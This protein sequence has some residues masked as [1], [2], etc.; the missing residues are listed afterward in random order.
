MAVKRKRK[1]NY[2][3]IFYVVMAFLIILL[4]IYGV[5]CILKSSDTEE[6]YREA[7]ENS[8]ETDGATHPDSDPSQ[9]YAQGWKILF[10]GD[11][12]FAGCIGRSDLPGGDYDLLMQSIMTRLITLDGR[13]DVLPGHGKGSTIADEGM[14]NPFLQPFNEPDFDF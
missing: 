9:L 4:M 10:S 12:L 8:A 6:T 3:R 14:K 13:T 1:V 7:V 11:T 5:S 2:M